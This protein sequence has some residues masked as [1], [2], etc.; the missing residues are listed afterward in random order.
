[1]HHL[2]FAFF[3]GLSS[4][5]ATAPLYA[6]HEAHHDHSE[7]HETMSYAEQ[8]TAAKTSSNIQIEQ[9]WIRLLPTNLPSAGY[10]TLQNNE[11]KKIELIA[12]ATPSYQQVMLHQTIETDGMTKMQRAEKIEIPAKGTLVF[13][14]GGLHAMFEKPTSTLKVGESMQLE[15]LFSDGQKVSTDCKVNPAKALSFN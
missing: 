9:C 11:N 7:R 1:M 4:L 13:E 8:F 12:A 5:L 3:L 10:F 2:T 15:L 14:P 6:A